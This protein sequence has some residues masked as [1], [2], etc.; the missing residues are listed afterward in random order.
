MLH[1]NKKICIA[2]CYCKSVFVVVHADCNLPFFIAGISK[3]I[4][5]KLYKY[6]TNN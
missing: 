2:N 3:N 1:L 6:H 4:C 5:C